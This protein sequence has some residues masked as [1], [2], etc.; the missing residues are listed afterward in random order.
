MI[1]SLRSSDP[2]SE[3]SSGS[4]PLNG[5]MPGGGF[6][7]FIALGLF[8]G[9]GCALVATR[10]I[11]EMS[12]T[13]AALKA[14]REVQADKLAPELFRQANEWFFKAR[15]EYKLK[16]FSLAEEYSKKSRIYAEQ[17]EFEVLR[18]GAARIEVG[19]SD[20]QSAGGPASPPPPEPAAPIKP[21]P[22]DYPTPKATP[23][24]AVMKTENGGFNT[25]SG[26]STLAV[27]SP[28]P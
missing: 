8:W 27:P 11:Q 12:D 5:G 7:F 16:N 2:N 15:Q 22:Y 23:V 17:A 25:G 18:T 1:L 6:A 24:E 26:P 4:S 19:P 20:P 13:V 9:T 10:P 28:N 21:S 3:A 14:A